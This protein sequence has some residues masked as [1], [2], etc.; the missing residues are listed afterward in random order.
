MRIGASG[1]RALGAPAALATIPLGTEVAAIAQVAA[2]ALVVLAATT[3]PVAAH[4]GV[5]RARAKT[6]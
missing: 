2:L 3:L 1:A 4:A 6:S 5:P